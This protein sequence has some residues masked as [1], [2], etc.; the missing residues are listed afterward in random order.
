[1]GV[2]RGRNQ[3]LVSRDLQLVDLGAAQERCFEWYIVAA[4]AEALSAVIS[5]L[6]TW[7]EQ[8]T[9]GNA[10]LYAKFVA[11]ASCQP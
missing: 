10:V 3:R 11:A 9:H 2:A 7:E 5:S 4:A 6:L 8:D 1:M